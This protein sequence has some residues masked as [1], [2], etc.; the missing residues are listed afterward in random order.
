VT[1]SGPTGNIICGTVTS[2]S[3]FAVVN[4]LVNPPTPN[5]VHNGDFSAGLGG[6]VAFATPD[7]SYIVA[8]VA[9]GVLEFY[10]VPPPP[11]TTNQAVMLQQTGASLPGGV[12][13]VAEF[14]LGNSS[15]VRKRISVLLHDAN[16]SDLFVCTFWLPPNLP[17]Q[18]YRMESHTTR[19]WTDATVSFYAATTGSDGGV[20]RIDDVSVRYAPVGSSARTACT[21]PRTPASQPEPDGPDI[22]V[23]GSFGT[24]LAPWATFGQIVHQ[25]DA[26]VFEF[27]RPPGLP[28]GVVF[29]NSGQPIPAGAILT[30]SLQL[31]NSS[32]VRKRVTVLLHDADFSDLSACT[33]WL[34]PGQALSPY[35]M[36]AYSTK[37]W[38]SAMVSVYGA[39]L[40][41]EQWIRLDNVT[42]KHT[43][44]SETAGVDCLEPT[45]VVTTSA[46]PA[47]ETPETV[48]VDFPTALGFCLHL[49][50]LAVGQCRRRLCDG[51]IAG[52]T[53][54]TAWILRLT[55]NHR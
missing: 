29:Q 51:E 48:C 31:G 54:L 9:S 22:V 40:G 15:S 10:R 8:G 37:A 42:V 39:T 50:H 41:T 12:G 46:Q 14:Q 33:F 49:V 27:Y 16:F 55:E 3:A 32:S 44:S 25:I 26:G 1:S 47:N 52:P 6:W 11:G 43:P 30:T 17:L 5:L 53:S 45:E 28:A 35:V 18:T 2:L 38:T 23:N 21:D 36:R 24:G 20:Y 34:P 19:P 4:K 7:P 13:I